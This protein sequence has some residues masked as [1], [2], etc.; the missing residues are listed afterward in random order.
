MNIPCIGFSPECFRGPA[1]LPDRD[2]E[3]NSLMPHDGS[4]TVRL[5]ARTEAC[6]G[7]LLLSL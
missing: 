7:S 1:I 3:G 4:S 2:G 5:C 6:E